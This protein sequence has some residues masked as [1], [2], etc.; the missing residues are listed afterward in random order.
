[1]LALEGVKIL[2]LLRLVPGAFC[3]T[4]LGDLGAD[5]LKIEEPEVT[6]FRGSFPG[7]HTDEI[8]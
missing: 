4:L 3:T 5:V 1:M 7:E 8:L 2:D 6:E